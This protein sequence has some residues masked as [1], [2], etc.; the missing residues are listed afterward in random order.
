MRFASAAA[1]IFGAVIGAEKSSEVEIRDPVDIGGLGTM[2]YSYWYKW[3]DATP[4]DVRFFESFE[5][6]KADGSDFE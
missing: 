3:D 6:A 2:T 5:F 1:L 4:L